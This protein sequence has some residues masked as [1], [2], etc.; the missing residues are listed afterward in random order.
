MYKMYE[1][2]GEK[3]GVRCRVFCT[4]S[5]FN[6]FNYACIYDFIPD[7]YTAIHS[8]R[9]YDIYGTRFYTGGCSPFSS[10]L[11]NFID[12]LLEIFQ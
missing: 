10:N 2:V 8:Q 9:A 5:L 6:S 11:C 3:S 1:K 7:K 12:G 4:S